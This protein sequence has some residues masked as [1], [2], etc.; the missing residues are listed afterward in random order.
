MTRPAAIPRACTS[1]NRRRNRA[2]VVCCV[3]SPVVCEKVV[4]FLATARSFCAAMARSA[5][6]DELTRIPTPVLTTQGSDDKP[7][8][9]GVKSAG[10]PSAASSNAREKSRT[11][12]KRSTGRF[13]SA[14]LSTGSTSGG[15]SG[16]IFVND[17]GS[18]LVI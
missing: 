2:N 5:A 7:I 3:D 6:P 12:A 15:R 1:L 16:A 11:P 8:G 10:M 18:R 13:D 9:V 17:G 14:R 4:T